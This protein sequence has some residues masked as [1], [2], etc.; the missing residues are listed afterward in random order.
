MENKKQILIVRGGESFD[1]EENFFE[2]LR[3]VKL[4]LY[5]D[6]RNW[7]DWIIW[8]LSET[9]DVLVPLMP[10]KQKAQYEAWQI[11]FERHL[12]FLHDDSPI[13][14]GHSLG[15][16]FLLKYLSENKFPKRI[17]QLHLVA[18]YVTDEYEIYLER[19]G[20]FKFDINKINTIKDICDEIHVWHSKD[21]KVVAFQ[22]AEIVK[23]NLPETILHVFEDRGHF[24]QPA[25]MEL[26]QVIKEV[27]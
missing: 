21:D 15:A 19:L 22:N 11:W 23:N 18:P 13:L 7:R 9:H 24:N 16:T 14:V 5:E 4:D 17:K 2:Y 20:T 26:L 1:N 12:E 8:A 6:K 3:T 10:C 25:F 27:H